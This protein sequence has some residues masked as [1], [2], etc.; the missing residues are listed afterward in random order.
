MAGR[1]KILESTAVRRQD[2]K[3]TTPS[4]YCTYIEQFKFRDAQ[5]GKGSAER[6]GPREV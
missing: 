4:A 5:E 2:V 6:Q 3:E 1:A